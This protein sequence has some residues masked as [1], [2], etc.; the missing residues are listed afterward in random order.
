ME[1]AREYGERQSCKRSS[2]WEKGDSLDMEEVKPTGLG[3]EL[4]GVGRM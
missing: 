2:R 3:L 1:P 4:G